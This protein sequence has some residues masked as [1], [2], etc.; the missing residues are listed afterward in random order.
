MRLHLIFFSFVL[1]FGVSFLI[2]IIIIIFLICGTRLNDLWS[3]GAY[4][5]DQ[6]LMEFKKVSVL[7]K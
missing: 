7:N 5:Y 6:H 1:H 4:G 2:T 3:K